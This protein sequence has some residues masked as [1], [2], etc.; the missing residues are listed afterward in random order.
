MLAKTAIWQNYAINIK[1][2]STLGL[3]FHRVTTKTKM[4][5]WEII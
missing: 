2:F 3:F 4:Y 1:Y 5:L